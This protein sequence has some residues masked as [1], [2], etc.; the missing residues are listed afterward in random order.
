LASGSWIT[1]VRLLLDASFPEPSTTY[2]PAGVRLERWQGGVSDVD[3]LRSA[4][5]DGYDGVIFLGKQTLARSEL[6]T[7]VIHS[8]CGMIVTYT[9]DPT[10]AM[11]NFLS[12]LRTIQMELRPGHVLLV[13]AD[14]VRD[15]QARLL[16]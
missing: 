5:T 9:Q 11:T 1:E 4:S 15:I 3:L 6:L 10:R 12:H 7:E 13:L 14:G 8:S 2:A 16:A